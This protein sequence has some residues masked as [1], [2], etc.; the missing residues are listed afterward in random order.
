M[1]MNPRCSCLF[2]G[3]TACLFSSDTW[4][5]LKTCRVHISLVTKKKMLLLCQKKRPNIASYC[6]SF[7]FFSWWGVRGRWQM[8]TALM[9][10]GAISARC[11]MP[12][13]TSTLRRITVT[14]H[15]SAAISK[16]FTILSQCCRAG[17]KRW[18]QLDFGLRPTSSQCISTKVEIRWIFIMS[19]W[20]S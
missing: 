15:L 8:A 17:A 20:D 10:R 19:G 13:N 9:Q 18:S 5:H 4:I 1:L 11:T 16:E 2:L 6:K 7:G 3:L 14:W 12:S